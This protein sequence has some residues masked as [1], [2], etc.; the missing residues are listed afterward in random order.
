M[1]E[2]KV[3]DPIITFKM[4]AK[5]TLSTKMTKQDSRLFSLSREMQKQIRHLTMFQW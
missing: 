1:A 3:S 5:P 4:S 2:T